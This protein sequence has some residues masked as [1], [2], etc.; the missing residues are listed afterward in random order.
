MN[1]SEEETKAIR[2]QMFSTPTLQRYKTFCDEKSLPVNVEDISEEAQIGWLGSPK[3]S[4]VVLYTCGG[5][6]K[7]PATPFHIPLIY[8]GVHPV[9]EGNEVAVGLIMHGLA[10]SCRYPGQIRDFILV[11]NH[12]LKTRQANSIYLAGDSS[13]SALI[14]AA[15]FHLAHPHPHV[16][17][18]ELPLSQAFAGGLLISPA[19][20]LPSSAPSVDSNNGKDLYPKSSLVE[21][22]DTVSSSTE[23]GFKLTMSDPYF[24]PEQAPEAWFSNL[25]IGDVLFLFGGKEMLH[26]DLATW[27]V[28]FK[29]QHKS[30]VDIHDNPDHVH[31]QFIVD[32]MMGGDPS[33]QT[34]DIVKWLQSLY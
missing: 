1:L 18:L 26:D 22:R 30:L 14:I 32:A 10:P 13:G 12:I 24:A 9:P 21:M 27:A 33:V 2:A 5:G 3:A 20:P 7:D 8:N 29:R 25:P 11:L 16:P 4:K 31:W 23:E 6:L 15:L 28:R 34:S 19:F 17:A